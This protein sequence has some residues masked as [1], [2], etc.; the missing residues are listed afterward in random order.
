MASAVQH[1][2]L[3]S[4]FFPLALAP[5]SR[6]SS[7]ES[8]RP[9]AA[10]NINA[11]MPVS[12]VASTRAPLSNSSRTFSVLGLAAANISALEIGAGL[13]QCIHH[14]CVALLQCQQ[15]HWRLP[16]SGCVRLAALLQ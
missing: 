4:V 14:R 1:R 2:S 15:H 11:V 10:A 3:P 12:V 9:A 13:H 16:F 6:S 7:A 8:S 5:R